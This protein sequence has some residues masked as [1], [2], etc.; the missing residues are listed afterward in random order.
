LAVSAA[1]FSISICLF[2]ANS[3]KSYFLTLARYLDRD[4]PNL[5]FKFEG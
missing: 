1:S 5:A 3:F 2:I 4:T